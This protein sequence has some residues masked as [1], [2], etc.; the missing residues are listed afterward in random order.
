MSCLRSFYLGFEQL[1][2]IMHQCS[3]KIVIFIRNEEKLHR[4]LVIV[5]GLFLR[6]RNIKIHFLF[7]DIE[8]YVTNDVSSVFIK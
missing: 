4:V 7:Y 6:F 5:K 1:I 3:S 8:K 2:Y